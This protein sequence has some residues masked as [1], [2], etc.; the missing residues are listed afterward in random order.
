MNPSRLWLQRLKV[1]EKIKMLMWLCFYDAISTVSFCFKRRLS[2][3]DLCSRY[4]VLV[5]LSSLLLL[6]SPPC[7]LL[8]DWIGFRLILIVSSFQATSSLRCELF[9]IWKGLVLASTAGYRNVICEM[10]CLVAL[11]LIQL[12][13]SPSA[14]E[15]DLVSKIKEILLLNWSVQLSLIQ[16]SA[17]SVADYMARFASTTQH[18]YQE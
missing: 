16:R 18:D 5:N 3:S 12:D 9:A 11:Q 15:H 2:N 13:S 1:L 14:V 17:N 6:L 4:A 7:P 8:L 10:D